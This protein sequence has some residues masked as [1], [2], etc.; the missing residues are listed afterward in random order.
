MDKPNM[1]LNFGIIEIPDDF[2]PNP[3]EDIEPEVEYRIQVYTIKGWVDTKMADQHSKVEGYPNMVNLLSNIMW[4]D[5]DKKASY[6]I[7]KLTYVSEDFAVA[8]VME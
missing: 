6:R 3:Q 1:K 2:D 5:L 4:T 8:E 7:L